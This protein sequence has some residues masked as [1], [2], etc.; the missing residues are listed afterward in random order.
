MTRYRENTL[1]LLKPLLANIHCSTALDFG[2][3]DGWFALQ[4]QQVANIQHITALD[5][6]KRDNC[7]VAPIIYSGTTIPFSDEQFELTYAIDVLHHCSDP[8]QSLEELLRCTKRYILLKDHT[9]SNTLGW[10]T[11]C[12][13]DEI[14]NRRFHVP[15]LYHYQKNWSWVDAIEARGFRR[16]SLI[17][18][19]KVH[20][21]LL[22]R[23][24]NHLQFIGLWEKIGPH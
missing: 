15:S 2:C 16:I 11:L 4:L 9:Y 8:Q 6:L 3:G 21:G 1:A 13:L 10:L 7:V 23:A 22:G 18:P 19:A 14:G 17:Y 5:V 24:T 20:N 12:A